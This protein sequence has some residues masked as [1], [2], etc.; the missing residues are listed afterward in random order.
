M[1]IEKKK[2]LLEICQMVPI[3]LTVINEKVKK[4]VLNSSHDR[5]TFFENLSHACMFHFL[6]Y[7]V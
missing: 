7:F 1:K 5:Y 6:F 2:S 4:I 3:Q